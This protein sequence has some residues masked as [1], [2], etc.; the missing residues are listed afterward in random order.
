MLRRVLLYFRGK[1]S[2]SDPVDRLVGALGKVVVELGSAL[3]VSVGF[4]GPLLLLDVLVAEL[5]LFALPPYNL[6]AVGGPVAFFGNLFWCE[7]VLD[8]RQVEG[9]RG[10]PGQPEPEEVEDGEAESGQPGPEGV[11]G[12]GEA[13]ER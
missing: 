9:E 13:S 6:V 11:E 3:V 2:S 1:W 7:I 4:L 8:L 10:E 5:R 12:G